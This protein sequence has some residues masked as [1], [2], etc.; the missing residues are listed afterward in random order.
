[1]IVI[2]CIDHDQELKALTIPELMESRL[3]D[4]VWVYWEGMKTSKDTALAD[5]G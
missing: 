3:G 5:F 4:H 2:G 1:M